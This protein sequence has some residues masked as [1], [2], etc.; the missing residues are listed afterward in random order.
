MDLIKAVL[1][2]RADIVERILEGPTPDEK[3]YRG[4]LDG[5]L[6]AIELLTDTVECIKVE[7]E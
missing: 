1:E 5:Y 7:L 6:Q 2:C 3:Y 4:K